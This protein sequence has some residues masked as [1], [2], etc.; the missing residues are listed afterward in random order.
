MQDAGDCVAATTQRRRSAA[1]RRDDAS[2]NDVGFDGALGA[3]VGSEDD[4]E[5]EGGQGYGAD[6]L[7]ESGHQ[8][9]GR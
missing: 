9:S 7:G 6:V 1:C 2:A 3:S 4:E 5:E 8:D